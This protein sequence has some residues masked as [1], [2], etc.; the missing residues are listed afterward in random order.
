MKLYSFKTINLATFIGGPLAGGILI[1][2]NFSKLNKEKEA[3]LTIIIT[4]AFSI[5]L[6]S[7]LFLASDKILS[8]IPKQ[9]IPLFYTIIISLIVE[10]YQNKD[11]LEFFNNGGEKQSIWKGLGISLI[12]VI[13]I[14]ILLF[15]FS[16]LTPPF[17]GE[18]YNYDAS[19]NTIYYN[20]TYNNN[21]KYL[22]DELMKHG[23]FNDSGNGA[24]LL[25]DNIESYELQIPVFNIYW[26]DTENINF[27]KRFELYLSS[28]VLMKRTEIILVHDGFNGREYKEII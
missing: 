20:G 8:D 7:F 27:F 26:E 24:V 14:L 4:L 28:Q 5:I 15:I 21:Y 19:G 1:Y 9:I 18:K 2:H 23:F 17:E 13:S 22:G 3:K 10:R 11:L 6:F 25:K 16:F 12:G